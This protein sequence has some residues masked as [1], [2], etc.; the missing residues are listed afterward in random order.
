MDKRQLT[1]INLFSIVLI[2]KWIYTYYPKQLT[3]Y[4][5]HITIIL[6]S[7]LITL[8]IPIYNYNRDINKAHQIL[9]NNAISSKDG[10]A[11]A[12]EY[13]MFCITQN[14]WLTNNFTRK[15]IYS[16]WEVR[17]L[18]R[19]I[20]KAKNENHITAVFTNVQGIYHKYLQ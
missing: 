8:Y 16:D 19:Y 18:S 17:A 12:T 9:I 10:T 3:R 11:E 13:S 6:I 5:N 1:C 7:I 20:T 15:K 14:N 4:N 2:I